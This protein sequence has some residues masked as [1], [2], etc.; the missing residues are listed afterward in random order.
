MLEEEKNNNTNKLI[1]L[2]EAYNES[3]STAIE[4]LQSKYVRYIDK[5]KYLIGKLKNS[6]ELFNKHQDNI[7]LIYDF[8]IG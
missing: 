8:L 3:I 5:E 2:R 6:K 7:T 1:I 4:S